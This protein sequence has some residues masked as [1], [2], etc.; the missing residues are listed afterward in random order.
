MFKGFVGKMFLD[1]RNG[2]LRFEKYT[3]MADVFLYFFLVFVSICVVR[4][5]MLVRCII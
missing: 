3:R 5:R 2:V 1:R 4:E